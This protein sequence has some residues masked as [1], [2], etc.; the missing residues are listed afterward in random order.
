MQKDPF[1]KEAEE[2]GL[3]TITPKAT[4]ADVE[5][6][7]YTVEKYATP[8]PS[9]A[10]LEVVNG[11][12]STIRGKE[13]VTYA[14]YAYIGFLDFTPDHSFDPKDEGA[15]WWWLWS[16]KPFSDQKSEIKERLSRYMFN[17]LEKE[18]TPKDNSL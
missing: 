11:I 3:D 7:S 6:Y 12:T 8:L 18:N 13:V 9:R 2:A 10:F 17:M 15:L 16:P 14:C 1:L 5:F 4:P